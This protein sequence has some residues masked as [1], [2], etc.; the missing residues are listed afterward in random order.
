M[1]QASESLMKEYNDL[2]QNI[3]KSE[4][5][6]KKIN[7]V[8]KRWSW[9]TESGKPELTDE[10][11]LRE[12]LRESGVDPNI[13]NEIS[14]LDD[15]YATTDFFRARPTTGDPSL[16]MSDIEEKGLPKPEGTFAAG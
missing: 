14:I 3:V 9:K 11:A 7:E 6:Q 4:P 1:N 13:L 16:F 10:V 2:A 15:K 5:V 8:V 12:A